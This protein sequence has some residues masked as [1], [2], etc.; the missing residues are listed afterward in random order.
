MFPGHSGSPFQAAARQVTGRATEGKLKFVVID[1]VMQGGTVAPMGDRG[2]WIPIKPAT[3]GAFAMAM[4]RWIIENNRFNAT[5]L[6]APN[7]KVAKEKGFNSWTNAC[8]LVINDPNHPNDRKVLRAEDLGLPL[9]PLPEPDPL[10]PTGTPV[11]K[12]DYFIVMDKAEGKPVIYTQS[13]EGDLFFSGEVKGKNGKAIKVQT[14]F[15]FLKESAFSK[16]ISAFA[17]DCGVPEDTIIEIAKEF[18]SHGT[19]VGIDG[20]GNTAAAN[21]MDGAMAHHVLATLVGAIYKK[22]GLI[23]GVGGASFNLLANQYKLLG[24]PKALPPQ[25]LPICRTG[26]YEE[27]TEYKNKVA[28]GENPYP[29][30]LPWYSFGIMSFV[31]GNSDNQ[32]IYSMVNSYPYQAKVLMVW[33]ANP[34]HSTPGAARKEVINE[35]KKVERIPLFIAFDAY[36]G[37]TTALADYIIP[38]TTPYESW[39]LPAI[40]GNFA[41][42]G[43]ALRWP[44]VQPMT[45]KLENGRYA[46]YENYLI[47]VAKKIGIPG[48]GDQAI[49]G[50]DQKMYPLNKPEDFFLKAVANVAFDETPVPDLSEVES[51]MQDLDGVAATWRNSVKPEEWSKVAYVMSRG[52]RFASHESGFVGDNY[53]YA[54]PGCFQIYTESLATAM[55]SFTGKPFSGVIGYHPEAF[56]DGTPLTKAFPEEQWPLK[57]ASY[58]AKFRSATMLANSM[59]RDLNATNH[60]EINSD[61]ALQFGLKDGEKV[62]LISATGGEAVGILKARPGIAAGTVAVAFGYGHW[63]YG[64][65]AH[66]V[67]DKNVGGDASLGTGVLLSGIGL[68][69]PSFKTIFGFSEMCT[70]TPSRNGGVYRLEKA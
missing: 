9:P 32:T 16:K 23:P 58:K 56:A 50:P 29:S 31:G 21:G 4:I 39:G 63:E 5:F 51:K 70:G 36:M 41:G 62:K 44:V 65:R 47:D 53:K 37:E 57:G 11:K 49:P 67:G 28:K 24:L 45:A 69:D 59:L 27:T 61:D 6:T 30:K 12:P 66:K 18:T 52:G 17:K 38:D 10:Q 46:C 55:N 2:K 3:D 13:T 54:N 42:K 26:V 48:Y 8:H 22:G 34:L 20:M 35:M 15:L 68:V 60:I 64:A 19:K 43:T 14:G 25:G 40:W 33:M 1:P 7:L